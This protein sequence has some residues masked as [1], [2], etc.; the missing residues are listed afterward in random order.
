M[1]GDSHFCSGETWV[2]VYLAPVP[3]PHCRASV[4]SGAVRDSEV[5]ERNVC[6][7]PRAGLELRF[8]LSSPF[9]LRALH[10]WLLWRGPKSSR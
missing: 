10:C 8:E 3:V 5:Q 4:C 7:A 9:L 6:L 1:F 2:S